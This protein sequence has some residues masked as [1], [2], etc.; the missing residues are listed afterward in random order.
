MLN[1][2]YD[3][4]LDKLKAPRGGEPFFYV[5]WTLRVTRRV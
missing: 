5:R 1:S 2:K 4:H 3:D